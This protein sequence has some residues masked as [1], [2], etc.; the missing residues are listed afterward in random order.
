MYSKTA[1]GLIICTHAGMMLDC[2]GGDSIYVL[3]KNSNNEE[4]TIHKMSE[5]GARLDERFSN[6][7]Y[8]N[9][10]YRLLR[11]GIDDLF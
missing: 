11:H 8:S 5:N 1:P 7:Y 4:S 2:I 3:N 6:G 9:S 10:R